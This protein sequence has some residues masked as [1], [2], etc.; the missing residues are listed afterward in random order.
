VAGHTLGDHLV[1]L[2]DEHLRH[3]WHYRAWAAGDG[4]T[5]G[6]GVVKGW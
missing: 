2:D 6:E 5:A 1:V 3:R 4:S